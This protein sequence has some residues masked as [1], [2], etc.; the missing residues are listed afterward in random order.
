MRLLLDIGNSRIKWACAAGGRLAGCAGALSHEGRMPADLHSLWSALPIPSDGVL[1]V[2]VAAPSLEREIDDW[3][4]RY[5]A[6]KLRRLVTPRMGGGIQIA[7]SHPAALGA[8]RWAA[9]VGARHLDLLPACVVDCGTAVTLDAVDGAGRHL[10]G[11]IAP[12][13]EAMRRALTERTHRLPAVGDGHLQILARD[14]LTGIRS[15]TMLGLATLIDGLV[16]RLTESSGLPLQPLLTG[17]DAPRLFPW[18]T[19]CYKQV[20]DL[21]LEGLAV[22]SEDVN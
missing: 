3:V 19:R 1:A 7:Y 8:D 9:M 11:V 22:L 5:W 17:G 12:G 15:G 21:V 18:F 16:D 10:G 2:S 20:P 6:C 4:Q 14:T 13:L